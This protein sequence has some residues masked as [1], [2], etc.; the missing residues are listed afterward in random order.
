[1]HEIF[2]MS[3]AKRPI[4]LFAIYKWWGALPHPG[5]GALPQWYVRTHHEII[6]YDQRRAISGLPKRVHN[7]LVH[8]LIPN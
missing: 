3:G 8:I 4:P 5:W 1:M 6:N 7:K 2:M